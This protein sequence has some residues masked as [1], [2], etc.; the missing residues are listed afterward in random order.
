MILSPVSTTIVQYFITCLTT[1]LLYLY[2]KLTYTNSS[3]NYSKYEVKNP[4]KNITNDVTTIK[5]IG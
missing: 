2:H 4:V 3:I 1:G 5:I